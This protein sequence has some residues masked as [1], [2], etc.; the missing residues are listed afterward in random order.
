MISIWILLVITF[1]HWLADFVC[2]SDWM[3]QNKSKANIPLLVHVCVYGLVLFIP[4]L[5]LFPFM[6]MVVTFVILNVL[7]HFSTDFFTSRVTSYLWQRKQVHWFFTVIGF[8]QFLHMAALFS[9]YVA[10]N[11]GAL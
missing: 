1:T 4:S 8:D 6:E 2:Q 3:A 5:W 11:N 7:L 9:T 10:I